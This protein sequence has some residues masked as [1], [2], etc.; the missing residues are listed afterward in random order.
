MLRW[1]RLHSA[2][3]QEIGHPSRHLRRRDHLDDFPRSHEVAELTVE[4]IEEGDESLSCHRH[5][6]RAGNFDIR[7]WIAPVLFAEQFPAE[8]LD[9]RSVTVPRFA[10]TGAAGMGPVRRLSAINWTMEEADESKSTTIE[11]QHKW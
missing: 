3:G 11:S 4:I 1:Q 7:Q 9:I 8:C 2:L 5:R 6:L 10:K